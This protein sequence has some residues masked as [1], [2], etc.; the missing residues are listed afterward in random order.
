MKKTYLL[1][2]V[3]LSCLLLF[4]GNALGAVTP[5]SPIPAD[6][7]TG[8]WVNNPTLSVLLNTSG[9]TGT[10]MNGTITCVGTGDVYT[11]TNQANGTQTL[12]FPS[13]SKPL[14]ATTTYQWWVNVSD[15]DWTNTSY[16]FTTGSPARMSENTGFDATEL[17]LI[18]VLTIAMILVVLFVAIDMIHDKKPDTK[19]LMTIL[20]AVIIMVIALGFI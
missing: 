1:G 9:V 2:I 8:V 10:L 17:L 7:A 16:N 14:S 11:I 3:M 5:T 6:D 12:T 20:I 15:G 18:G 13:A 19:K 4:A